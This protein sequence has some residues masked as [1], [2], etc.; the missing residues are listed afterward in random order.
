MEVFVIGSLLLGIGFLKHKKN[1]ESFENAEEVKIATQHYNSPGSKYLRERINEHPMSRIQP[2]RID[3]II[4]SLSGVEMDVSEFKTP[5]MVPFYKGNIKGSSIDEHGGVGFGNRL[6]MFTGSNKQKKKESS[7]LFAPKSQGVMNSAGT[8]VANVDID[9]ENFLASMPISKIYSNE[10]PVDKQVIGKPTNFEIDDMERMVQSMTSTT[11]DL[12]PKDKPKVSFEGRVLPGRD[13]YLP[14]EGDGIEVS[15][16]MGDLDG[17]KRPSLI[18]ER[19]MEPSSSGFQKPTQRP[20]ILMSKPDNHQTSVTYWG[21]SITNTNPNANQKLDTSYIMPFKHNLNKLPP[22]PVRL[23][24]PGMQDDYG[25]S[26]VN[27]YSNNRDKSQHYVRATSGNINSTLKAIISPIQDILRETKKVHPTS[28][29]VNMQRTHLKS[30]VYDS[31]DV[32]RTTL[33]ETALQDSECINMKGNVY[34]TSVYTDP[35]TGGLRTTLKETIETNEVANLSGSTYPYVKN[36]DSAKPV[37]KETTLTSSQPINLSSHNAGIIHDSDDIMKTSTKETL[38]QET[39]L[40]NITM[41]PKCYAVDPTQPNTRTT[42]RETIQTLDHSFLSA[43]QYSSYDQSIEY[44]QPSRFERENNYVATAV[45]FNK[46]TVTNISELPVTQRTKY[47][48]QSHIGGMSTNSH[49]IGGYSVTEI[50]VDQTNRHAQMIDHYGSGSGPSKMTDQQYSDNINISDSRNL[51]SENLEKRHVTN[52][53]VKI[54]S[55]SEMMNV[56]LKKEPISSRPNFIQNPPD[57][58]HTIETAYT[59]K[60]NKSKTHESERFDDLIQGANEQYKENP[61][62]ILPN[63]E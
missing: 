40:N 37:T 9:R 60:D 28:H 17:P 26:T 55:G 19:S 58:N 52:E 5:D 36:E 29:P 31:D 50:N 22:G 27:V 43:P 48:K 61:F 30:T 24:I 38:L 6:E 25:K 56:E 32:A 15:S 42:G 2:S 63:S 23:K 49:S 57:I 13:N 14:K 12:R 16:R 51:I 7:T 3:P 21:S 33:K 8:S 4:S 10:A 47:Q 46:P 34:K 18:D 39:T 20:V 59:R 54:M 45:G 35:E 44:S 41:Q 53:N 1:K 11:D 62:F